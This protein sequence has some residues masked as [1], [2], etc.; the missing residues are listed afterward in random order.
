[1][2]FRIFLISFLSLFLELTL[3]RWVSTEINVF[4]YL[5]NVILVCCLFGLGCGLISKK[6]KIDLGESLKPL[7]MLVILIC[8]PMLKDNVKLVINALTSMDDFVVWERVSFL[9]DSE[10]LKLFCLA[11]GLFA[12]L[13]ICLLVIAIFIPIGSVIADLFEQATNSILSYSVNLLG[14][15]GGIILF[16]ILGWF[17]TPPLLWLIIVLLIILFDQFNR[18]VNKIVFLSLLLL[19]FIIAFLSSWINPNLVIWSNYQKLEV[20]KEARGY[21]IAVNN[22]GYQQIF[23]NS[24]N[25]KATRESGAV[26][27]GQY[28]IPSLLYPKAQNILIVGSGSGN[29]VAGAIRNSSAQITAVEIDRKIAELGMKYHPE[30]PYDNSRVN[31]KITDAREFFS[32][33]N[34]KFDLIIFG[35]LDSH[36]TVSLTNARLDNF[37]YTEEAMEQVKKLLKPGGVITLIFQVNHQFILNRIYK[38]LTKVFAVNPQV[39]SINSSDIGWGGTMFI[40]G[41]SNTFNNALSKNEALNNYIK[42]ISMPIEEKNNPQLDAIK[43]ITDDWPYLYLDK[44]RIPLLVV[45]F[46]TTLLLV[47]ARISRSTINFSNIKAH[48]KEFMYF[49]FLGTGFM[50]LE[51]FGISKAAVCF[52]NTWVIN[53]IVISIILIVGLIANYFS[54]QISQKKIA[55][56]TLLSFFCCLILNSVN[57]SYLLSY[58]YC[59]RIILVSL[60]LSPPLF[61]SG[62]AFAIVFRKTKHQEFCL[63][64]NIFGAF[65]GGMIQ[66]V[67]FYTGLSF[68]TILAGI[69]YLSCSY[70]GKKIR[71]S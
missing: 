17:A 68:L 69:C 9:S 47:G 6:E 14:S 12:T 16:A 20:T 70:F 50:L 52:G 57:F 61:C 53:A 44:P 11:V 38:T 39:I 22:V 25:Y 13:A 34:E 32:N 5:Q 21:Y 35:L 62:L 10:G 19:N 15:L 36:T 7:L 3:I 48:N 43:I 67:S 46:L 42:N 30:K 4:A 2:F 58:S 56:I 27:Y 26:P 49:A 31:L 37:V 24:D 41:D 51:S 60:I 45:S 64:A 29:D 59:W 54:S 18:Q 8:V 63:G 66:L 71:I 40:T 1:M 33:T 23:D 55:V 65:I 28:D